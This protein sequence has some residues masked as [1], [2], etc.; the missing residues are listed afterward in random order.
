MVE[1]RTQP[2]E[3][4][5]SFIEHDH[6]LELPEC[7]PISHNPRP[8]STISLSYKGKDTFLEVYSLRKFV[9]SYRGGKDGVRSM[10]GMLQEITQACAQ[11]LGVEVRMEAM[12]HLE[13][14]QRMRVICYA[15]PWVEENEELS[16]IEKVVRPR[17]A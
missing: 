11:A 1:L 4:R 14:Q 16:D 10:E 12:L 3:K 2:N 8:G 7:C 17:G 9:D 13:P 15:F 6:I 5:C